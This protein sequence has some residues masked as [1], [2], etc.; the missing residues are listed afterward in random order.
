MMKI[1]REIYRDENGSLGAVV[2]SRFIDHP[3][4]CKSSYIGHVIIDSP[5]WKA[6]NIQPGDIV[7]SVDGIAVLDAPH[8]QVLAMLAGGN[9]PC[10]LVVYRPQH[11]LRSHLT[12]TDTESGAP[13][14][15]IDAMP[16]PTDL[17]GDIRTGQEPPLLLASATRP[18]G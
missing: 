10:R 2:Q 17:K 5:V 18:C 14:Q 3:N 11:H 13:H 8:D 4:A 9:D 16:H 15:H 6:K 12:E 7:A 1:E